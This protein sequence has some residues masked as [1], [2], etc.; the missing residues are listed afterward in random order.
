[1]LVDRKDAI[2]KGLAII[3]NGHGCES[4]YYSALY[5]VHGDYISE[6]TTGGRQL[7]MIVAS[8]L[9]EDPKSSVAGIAF[10]KY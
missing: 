4:L 3:R 2:A 5:S 7:A 10:N 8:I 9:V 6:R 1:M